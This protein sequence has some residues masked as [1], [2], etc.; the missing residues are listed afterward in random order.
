MATTYLARKLHDWCD[1]TRFRRTQ[2]LVMD[3]AAFISKLG[4]IEVAKIDIVP[5]PND[6]RLWR[7]LALLFLTYFD[8]MSQWK[9][10]RPVAKLSGLDGDSNLDDVTQA[11]KTQEDTSSTSEG[12]MRANALVYV[13]GLIDLED[14]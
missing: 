13:E 1:D 6:R 5:H 9:G 4:H 10:F 8:P 3:N 14:T 11:K 12:K 2:Q 7:S